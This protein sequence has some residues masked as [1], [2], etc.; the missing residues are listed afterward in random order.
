MFCVKLYARD[1]QTSRRGLR[2][3]SCSQ[4][5]YKSEI[6]ATSS[7]DG[8]QE[9]GYRANNNWYLNYD[10]LSPM[11]SKWPCGWVL[12]YPLTSPTV[13]LKTTESSSGPLT[14][15]PAL[16]PPYQSFLLVNTNEHLLSPCRHPGMCSLLIRNHIVGNSSFWKTQIKQHYRGSLFCFPQ[17]GELDLPIGS[18]SCWHIY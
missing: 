5:T 9:P 16:L 8:G 12:L 17:A 10:L 3:H 15:S 14:P 13:S 7:S 2:K 6:C 4:R 1:T 18:Y 11:A